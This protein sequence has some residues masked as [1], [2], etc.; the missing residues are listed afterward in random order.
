MTGRNFGT[1]IMMMGCAAISIR[2][3]GIGRN[4]SPCLRFQPS[5]QT[6]I[7]R[8]EGGRIL[9]LSKTER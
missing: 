3:Y 2:R 9:R 7:C 8:L 5:M 6:N 1:S 4:D